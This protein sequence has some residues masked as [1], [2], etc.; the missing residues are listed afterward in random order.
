MGQ[1]ISSSGCPQEFFPFVKTTFQWL[2]E[3]ISDHPRNY[4]LR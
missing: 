1:Y 4:I 3:Q 2:L